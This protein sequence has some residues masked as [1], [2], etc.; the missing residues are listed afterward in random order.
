MLGDKTLAQPKREHQVFGADIYSPRYPKI[1]NKLKIRDERNIINDLQPYDEMAGGYGGIDTSDL[2][3]N[4]GLQ[5]KFLEDKGKN[6]H[7]IIKYDRPSKEEMS[8]YEAT[9][10][11][12]DSK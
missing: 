5:L 1:E 6:L 7:D 3:D 4:I 2:T 9:R 8:R 11:K 10:N 12:K